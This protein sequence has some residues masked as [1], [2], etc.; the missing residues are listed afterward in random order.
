MMTQHRLAEVD[1][2]PQPGRTEDRVAVTQVTGDNRDPVAVMGEQRGQVRDHDRIVVDVG[3][4][5]RRA[6]LLRCH[7][8]VRGGWQ[9][10]AKVDELR[11]ALSGHPGDRSFDEPPALRDGLEDRRVDR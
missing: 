2:G 3:H 6:G 5:S 4:R 10:G 11:D 1:H 8:R 9:P 7:V